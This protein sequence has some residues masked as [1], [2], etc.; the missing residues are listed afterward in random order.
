MNID[1]KKE[2]KFDAD[3]YYKEEIEPYLKSKG[4][5]KMWN[6]FLEIT[7]T[8][9]FRNFIKEIRKKYNI[10]LNGFKDECHYIPPKSLSFGQKQEIENEIITKICEKY[11]LH[12]FD[13][14]EIIE[15]Y[16]YYNTLHLLG[17]LGSCGLFRVSD[18]I[19]EKEEPFSELFQRSDD[20]AY[21]IAVR[22]SPYASQRDLID[23]IKNRI[24][25][26]KE[27]QFLQNKYKDKNIKI[28]KI[29]TKNKEI[30]RRNDFIY[31]HRHSPRKEILY[32]LIEIAKRKKNKILWEL[33][34]AEIS[35]V[36]SLENKKR[37]EMSS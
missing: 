14:Y 25:W 32:L 23:F 19:E 13:Y 7:K 12:Y 21:P 29:K 24:I 28:G 11:K 36:I 34:Q 17:E 16:I 30:Q 9:Y 15:V 1:K 33:D 4:V 26:K 20:M 22:I 2:E 27:I 3:K 31:K 35:K 8:D 5:Q 18:I 10:P 37:K 6:Y